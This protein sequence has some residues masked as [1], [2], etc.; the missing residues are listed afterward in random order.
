MFT[1]DDIL[2]SIL[3][4]SKHV[5]LH[6]FLGMRRLSHLTHFDERLNNHQSE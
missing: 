4:W 3:K 5:D 6:E 2:P 1:P